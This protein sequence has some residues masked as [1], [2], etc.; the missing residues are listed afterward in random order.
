MRNEEQTQEHD[1]TAR[2]LKQADRFG[3]SVS[4]LCAIHCALLPLLIAVI[5]ALGVNIGGLADID[6]ALV[7]FV[8]CFG[9]LMLAIG[10]RRH[11]AYRAWALLIPGLILVW[12]GAFS[13]LHEH[14]IMHAIIMTIGGLLIA[15]AHIMNLR[16]NHRLDQHRRGAAC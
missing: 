10:Y 8:T 15:A 4:F 1:A 3:A 14:G 12:L 7:I 11:R 5:P 16:L 2:H 6:Q 13:F 9:L